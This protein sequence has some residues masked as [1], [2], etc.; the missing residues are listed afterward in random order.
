M[1]TSASQNGNGIQT[2]EGSSNA[3]REL[4]AI[5]NIRRERP[6]STPLSAQQ[7]NTLENMLATANGP[8]TSAVASPP[9]RSFISAETGQVDLAGFNFALASSE[10]L[11][12]ALHQAL[13]DL[14]AVKE[15]SAMLQNLPHELTD[16]LRR[17]GDLKRMLN[18]SDTALAET[19]AELMRVKQERNTTI[20]RLTSDMQT[21]TGTLG[22]LTDEL[23]KCREDLRESQ[24]ETDKV[25]EWS[26]GFWAERDR[27]IDELEQLRAEHPELKDVL[28]RLCVG[29]ALEQVGQEI[30]SLEERLSRPGSSLASPIR[31][32]LERQLSEA[33]QEQEQLKAAAAATATTTA[34]TSN[35]AHTLIALS[36]R[37]QRTMSDIDSFITEL[38][39]DLSS[40][41]QEIQFLK[42]QLSS[43]NTRREFETAILELNERLEQRDKALDALKNE[44]KETQDELAR[45][46]SSMKGD[47]ATAG[48]TTD[49]PATNKPSVPIGDPSDSALWVAREQ[50]DDMEERRAE[51]DLRCTE[52]E[53]AVIGLEEERNDGIELKELEKQRSNWTTEREELK[54]QIN[55]KE[56]TLNEMSKNRE[57]LEREITVLREEKKALEDRIAAASS[58][59]MDKADDTVLELDPEWRLRIQLLHGEKVNAEQQMQQAQEACQQAEKTVESVQAQMKKL[60]SEKRMLVERLAVVHRRQAE[61]AVAAVSSS[62]RTGKRKNLSTFIKAQQQRTRKS[63]TNTAES[64]RHHSPQASQTHI[65]ITEKIA[66][67]PPVTAASNMALNAANQNAESPIQSLERYRR[68][69]VEVHQQRKSRQNVVAPQPVTAT[70]AMS[71]VG[72]DTD[73]GVDEQHRFDNANDHHDEFMETTGQPMTSTAG[74]IDSSALTQ[75]AHALV[76]ELRGELYGVRSDRDML[77]ARVHRLEGA[78]QDAQER[79]N[80]FEEEAI[81]L[82]G[83]ISAFTDRVRGVPDIDSLLDANVHHPLV[84]ATDDLVARLQQELMTL[85]V[86]KDAIGME[87]EEGIRHC[88][89]EAA[90]EIEMRDEELEQWQQ[91]QSTSTLPPSDGKLPRM[92]QQLST[93]DSLRRALRD[94]L[95]QL[96]LNNIPLQSHWISLLSSDLNESHLTNSVGPD[97]TWL[98]DLDT[99]SHVNVAQNCKNN[100]M[101]ISD[102]LMIKIEERDAAVRI[103]E[104]MAAMAREELDLKEKELDTVRTN[105]V[106]ASLNDSKHEL[107]SSAFDSTRLNTSAMLEQNVDVVLQKNADTLME[108]D[109]L[110]RVVIGKHKHMQRQRT[111]DRQDRSMSRS[112]S[113]TS[114]GG[115]DGL[116]VANSVYEQGSANGNTESNTGQNIILELRE[117]ALQMRELMEEHAALKLHLEKVADLQDPPGTVGRVPSSMASTRFAG[118]VT[119][120][121]VD[122][123]AL[124]EIGGSMTCVTTGFLMAMEKLAPR[125]LRGVFDNASSSVTAVEE[126][127]GGSRPISAMSSASGAATSW[128]TG[129]I[130]QLRQR[131]A[132]TEEMYRQSQANIQYLEDTLHAERQHNQEPQLVQEINRLEQENRA[133][134][135]EIA[136]LEARLGQEQDMREHE[137][138]IKQQDMNDQIE[139][140]QQHYREDTRKLGREIRYLQAKCQREIAFRM[141]FQFQKRYLL[142]IIGGMESSE[143]EVLRMI[144]DMVQLPRRNSN[145]YQ[146][147]NHHDPT[148]YKSKFRAAVFTVIA[149]VRLQILSHSWAMAR[150]QRRGGG[151]HQ[152]VPSLPS[153]SQPTSMPYH[154]GPPPPPIP[155]QSRLRPHRVPPPAPS[156]MYADH[157]SLRRAHLYNVYSHVLHLLYSHPI[158]NYSSY[159]NTTATAQQQ[160]YHNQQQYQYHNQYHNAYTNRRSLPPPPP[161]H[162]DYDSH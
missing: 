41:Q 53:I 142:L 103:A 116:S 57:T 70:N 143:Q 12:R 18:Q 17:V 36:P 8:P 85:R 141:D 43:D 152:V 76:N 72:R 80:D 130:Q 82:R 161:S 149:I 63:A 102:N 71:K 139:Q 92:E 7:S 121:R 106:T 118:V 56:S 21:L 6:S 147:H 119:V 46:K 19:R 100:W 155:P 117:F 156:A 47:T 22:H 150:Q 32:D 23:A 159:S 154:H 10:D 146:Y 69:I 109:R 54:A 104:N 140:V 11:Q 24:N 35:N 51:L 94:M 68:R 144:S 91:P 50:Y 145:N 29:S 45:C 115:R 75:A 160:Q 86:E 62:S 42:R 90:R 40:S 31:V 39:T 93:I 108:L 61:N 14:T 1:A 74:G 148:P 27:L 129:A 25:R 3:A 55:A 33:R 89:E 158:I 132:H 77:R 126:S 30:Q 84:K 64:S 78:L 95:E 133:L 125:L 81:M 122:L 15:E 128:S 107:T 136:D 58:I 96:E 112:V 151:Q 101:T 137:W 97:I 138:T 105:I 44:L 114:S 13:S 135:E 26:E 34:T 60:E 9:V 111:N 5:R 20:D 38:E 37:H 48:A 16:T 98:K 88:Y 124:G 134:A 73:Y 28:G 99:Q 110:C 49:T 4:P 52:L 65:D 157:S 79:A 127:N 153:P 59:D 120:E 83:N 66:T 87:L 113:R 67:P 123:K 131:L 2:A 162:S